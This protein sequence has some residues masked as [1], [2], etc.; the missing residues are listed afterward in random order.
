M[1]TTTQMLAL[2]AL[3]IVANIVFRIRWGGWFWQD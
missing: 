3:A 2:V 1:I